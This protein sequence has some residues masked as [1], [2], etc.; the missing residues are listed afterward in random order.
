M[1]NQRNSHGFTKPLYF[2]VIAVFFASCFGDNIKGYPALQVPDEFK[3]PSGEEGQILLSGPCIM[4]EFFHGESDDEA[5]WHWFIDIDPK[6]EDK[7]YKSMMGDNALS[8]Y[9]SNIQMSKLDSI[10]AELMVTAR[11]LN[12]DN[13]EFFYPVDFD[14]PF[15]FRNGNDE[16]PSYHL[17]LPEIE[18]FQ[19]LPKTDLSAYSALVQKRA[20]IY[21]QGAFVNDAAH[22][23]KPEIHPLDA[24]AFALD[25]NGDPLSATVAS[26]SSWPKKELTWRVCFFANSGYH[27]INDEPYLERERTTTWYLDLPSDAY[28]DFRASVVKVHAE[29]RNLWLQ[30]QGYYFTD[31]NVKDGPDWEL[32]VD[33]KDG[34]KK[35]KVTATMNVPDKFGGIVVTDYAVSVNSG[36]LDHISPPEKE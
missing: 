33:P 20:F 21:L 14:L 23:F 16:H 3:S 13:D 11:H 30:H 7:L 31:L 34:R 28:D 17:S 29:Q 15:M 8:D 24:I 26:G 27:R 36:S 1:Y 10:Y 4:V 6:V 5:D 25:D 2:V 12:I 22:D 19:G 32:A 9:R 18:Q 35:L